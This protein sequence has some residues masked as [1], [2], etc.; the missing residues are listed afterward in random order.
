MK[1]QELFHKEFEMLKRGIYL[2]QPLLLLDQKMIVNWKRLDN[3]VNYLFHNDSKLFDKHP[4]QCIQAW[5][6]L[7]GNYIPD[8]IDKSK[9]L[10]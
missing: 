5:H 2:T 1:D 8:I 6:V 3:L 9:Y 4:E 7:F 10:N